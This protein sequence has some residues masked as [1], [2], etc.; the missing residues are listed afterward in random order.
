MTRTIPV[1][2]RFTRRQ[3]QVYEAVLKVLRQCIANLAP[4]KKLKDWQTEAE[5][6]T[7]RELVH[8]GLL[9]TAQIKRQKP[10]QPAFKKYLMHGVGHPI[11]LDVHDV[12]H[13]TKPIEAGWIMTVE[14]AIYVRDEGFAVRLENDVLV[15]RDGTVDLMAHIPIEAGDIEQLMGRRP[16]ARTGSNGNHASALK[17]RRT[18]VLADADA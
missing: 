2:G 7:E 6:M 18:P 8:L 9:T 12:G 16:T 15:T 1:N 14:P 17:A 13:T 4:G 10:D 5:Q 3:R 11:G